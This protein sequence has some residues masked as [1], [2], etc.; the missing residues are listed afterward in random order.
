[1]FLQFLICFLMNH[2][3]PSLGV[4][5]ALIQMNAAI[6][7]AGLFVFIGL[8]VRMDARASERRLSAALLIW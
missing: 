4:S 8:R 7:A 1:M 5:L 2:L 3:S 6:L